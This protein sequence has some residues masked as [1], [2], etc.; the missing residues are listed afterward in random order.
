MCLV[1]FVQARFN[2]ISKPLKYERK[3]SEVIRLHTQ[4]ELDNNS[5]RAN[6]FVSRDRT[7]PI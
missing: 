6:T 1:T 3:I 2:P 7:A 5:Y 4:R